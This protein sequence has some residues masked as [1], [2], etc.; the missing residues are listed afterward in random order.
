MVGEEESRSLI[1]LIWPSFS[2]T[3]G[4]VHCL[5]G[6]ALFFFCMWGRFFLIS[7]LNWSSNASNSN[8]PLIVTVNG[9]IFLKILDKQNTMCVSK[10]RCNNL[11][12]PLLNFWS[13]RTAFT[14]YCLLGWRSFFFRYVVMDPCFIHCHIPTQKILLY[15]AWTAPNSAI[16]RNF[17]LRSLKTIL[18]T[19]VVFPRT[20]DFGRPERSASSVFVRP[21]SN[22][23]YQSMFID[24]PDAESP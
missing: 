16:S 8:S 15:L 10:Y 12:S 13:L 21:R 7:A 4:T 20:A 1:H 11:A 5:S 18:W 19:F 6:T 14:S 22:S 24:F 2:W 17:N 3:C 9:F 23:A